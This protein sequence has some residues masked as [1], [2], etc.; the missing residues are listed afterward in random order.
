MELRPRWYTHRS[1]P[2]SSGRCR[3]RRGRLCSRGHFSSAA[4]RRRPEFP[5]AGAATEQAEAA[6][7]SCEW[8]DRGGITGGARWSLGEARLSGKGAWRRTGM[9]KNER[10]ESGSAH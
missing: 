3:R 8:R 1:T 6:M 2:P 10:G 5:P 4:A 9:D 7:R